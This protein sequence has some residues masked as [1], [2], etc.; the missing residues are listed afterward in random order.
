MKVNKRN[1]NHNHN[2]ETP[3][4]PETWELANQKI[5]TGLDEV[6]E[7]ELLKKKTI[8]VHGELTQEFCEKICKRLLFL[9]AKKPKEVSIIL[10]SV[11]GNIFD[12]LLLY[13]TIRGLTQKDIKV[14]IEARGLAASMAVIL[15]QSG[16]ERRASKYTR[17]LLHEASA[18]AAG[19]A[20][21][22]KDE[23]EELDKLNSMLDQIIVARS[24]ISLAKMRKKTKRREWWLS[25]EEALKFGIIDQ[26]V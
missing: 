16:T 15:L 20:S 3:E 21:K 18:N 6:I 19:E 1:H 2:E 17:F 11:G 12:G 8:V 23:S 26:I 4:V 9:A 22:L 7:M 10:N 5:Q 24:R 14:I 13:E 25:A